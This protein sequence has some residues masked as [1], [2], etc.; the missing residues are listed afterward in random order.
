MSSTVFPI[1]ISDSNRFG[2]PRLGGVVNTWFYPFAYNDTGIASGEVTITIP[3]TAEIVGWMLNITTAFDGTGTNTLNFGTTGALTQFGAA[4]DASVTGQAVT[5]FVASQMF[6]PMTG[7]IPLTVQYN[8][9]G[10]SAG[11]GVI[12]VSFIERNQA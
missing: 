1:Q 6:T 3:Y 12:A 9:T 8:G 11:A 10:A 5:G 7:D 2:P 4:F